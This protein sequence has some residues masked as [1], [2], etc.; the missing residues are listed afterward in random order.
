MLEIKDDKILVFTDIHVGIKSNSFLRLDIAEELIDDIVKT[1]IDKEIKTVLFC[2][3]WHHER[4]SI[5]VET[6]CR[7]IRMV[8][9]ITKH[10]K[11]YF[12]LGNHDIRDNVSTDITSVKFL[13]DIKGV[14]LI[15]KPTEIMMGENKVLMCPWLSELD[16]MEAESYDAMFGHFDISHKYLI[17]SYM[18]DHLSE[19]V[20]TAEVSNLMIKSGYEFQGIDSEPLVDKSKLT[21]K[22]NSKKHIGKF[23]DLCKKGGYIYSGHIH[24]RRTFQ[25]K[26]RKFTFLGSPLQLTWGDCNKEGNTS[27]RG[28]YLIDTKTMK[29]KF[30][31]NTVSPVHRKYFISELPLE[32][33][34]MDEIFDRESIEGNFIRLILNKQFDFQK[35][36]QI[37]NHIN[38]YG[39]KEPCVVDYDFSIDFES[40]SG[41]APDTASLK[42]SKLSYIHEYIETLDDSIFEDFSVDRETITRYITKYFHVTEELLG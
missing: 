39:P 19:D 16:G 9:K 42:T 24:H 26:G 7:S 37:I 17:E 18:E 4:P 11:L 22:V 2:G 38:S 10:A 25:L 32:S 31:E 6:M 36:S 1:I 40:N 13:Q 41:D 23:V 29:P 34:S 20:S 12:I 3:D 15:D 27:N 14:K 30:K 33:Q 21:G 28:Y 5:S 35:L 8:K